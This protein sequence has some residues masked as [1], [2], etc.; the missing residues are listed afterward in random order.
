M[1]SDFFAALLGAAIVC[2]APAVAASPTTFTYQGQLAQDSTPAEGAYEFEIRL[3]DNLGVQ[4]G[5][6]QTAS[7]I[8]TAGSFSMELDFGNGAFDGAERFLE[9]SVRSVV[10]GGAYVV[11]SPNQLVTS[12]PVAQF[13]LNGNEGPQGPVG[14]QGDPG[15]QGDPGT[16]GADGADGAQGPQ[17]DPGN[18]GADGA[19]GAQG[20]QGNQGVAGTPGD[21]HWTLNGSATYYNGGNVGIGTNNP[22]YPLDI[23]GSLAVTLRAENTNQFGKAIMGSANPV[24]GAGTGVHGSS[25]GASGRGV[26]GYA[27]SQ[28]GTNYGVYGRTESNTDGYSGYFQGGRVYLGNKVGIGVQD[29]LYS[30]HIRTADSQALHSENSSTTGVGLY[31]LATSPTGVNYG[32]RGKTN[33]PDGFASYFEGGKNYFEGN[34]GIGVDSPDASLH[35]QRV[36][37]GTVL[38]AETS[39]N[40]TFA[41]Y[42]EAT[43]SSGL[44]KGVVGDVYSPSGIGVQGRSY[45]TTGQSRGVYG[46]DHS[47]EGIGVVG[48]AV[49]FTGVNYGVW[50]KTNSPD[51]FAGY[52]AGGKNYFEGRVGIGEDAPSDQLH[53]NA[54]A[55]VNAFRVQTDG[56]TRIRVTQAGGVALGGNSS[57]VA[58]GDTYVVNNLGIGDATPDEKLDVIGNGVISGVLTVGTG[59]PQTSFKLGVSGTAAKT[60]GGSWA[61][62]SDKRLKKNIVSMTGSLDTISALRPVNFEYTAKD[63]FS[64][65]PGVQSGFIAQEV[66]RVIPQWVNTADDGYFYLDQ[67][68]YEA[69]IVDAIQELRIEKDATDKQLQDELSRLKLENESLKRRLDRMERIMGVLIEQ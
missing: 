43:S 28:F 31:T 30:L 19:P 68:G 15:A 55:G 66:Q 21:S 17:G 8:V 65:T 25:S 53:I 32:V 34:V 51:G 4:I 50:G 11:L 41:I 6:T 62:F 57:A 49:S 59:T 47:S 7:E 36:S 42:G 24:D 69:L 56:S 45:A 2:T 3:L 64:Y 48:V 61:V 1:R 18:D 10:D 67:V 63:H 5:V 23:D 60:G 39:S 33:S 20:P 9:I 54:P 27:T 46:E 58:N 12:A 38:H 37:L 29:P 44:T 40:S 52:F 26:F 14:P 16:P 13:A 22:F 35:V